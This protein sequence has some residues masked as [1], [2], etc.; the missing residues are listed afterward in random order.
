MDSWY[1]GF[2]FLE[3][4]YFTGLK[5]DRKASFQYLGKIT[6]ENR[7]MFYTMKEIIGPTFLLF[8]SDSDILEGFPLQRGFRM[9]LS[10]E[11]PANLLVL[12]YPEKR[13]RKFLVSDYLSSE[14]MM[15]SRPGEFHPQVISELDVRISTQTFPVIPAIKLCPVPRSI[16]FVYPG[17]RTG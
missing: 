10:N 14:D 1:S 8:E 16:P 7:D 5:L 2:R 17:R 9:Y 11:K 13:R 15:V 6:G 3:E 4:N 12:Y